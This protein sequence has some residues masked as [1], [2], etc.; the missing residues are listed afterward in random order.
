MGKGPGGC[1]IISLPPG[2]AVPAHS[3][4]ISFLVKVFVP[5]QITKGLT[6]TI[7]LPKAGACSSPRPSKQP[8]LLLVPRDH[9]TQLA[10]GRQRG[11]V[12]VPLRAGVQLECHRAIFRAPF[13]GCCVLSLL[14]GTTPDPAVCSPFLSLRKGYY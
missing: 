4:C 5:S 10:L 14:T 7:T 8:E 9:W 13:Y 3:L 1:I 6:L 12:T 2:K 11:E